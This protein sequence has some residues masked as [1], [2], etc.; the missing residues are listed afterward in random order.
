MAKRENLFDQLCH[1]NLP[2]ILFAILFLASDAYPIS[3]YEGNWIIN[4]EE[5]EALREPY[6]DNSRKRGSRFK[7]QVSV[8]GLPM[9]RS[10]SQRAM[11]RL[12]AQPPM[13]MRSTKMT[14]AFDG[15]QIKIQYPN[16]GQ[17]TLYKGEFRGR[18]TKWSAKQIKQTYKT[19]ERRV[20][21][22]WSINKQGRLLVVVK[23]KPNESKQVITRLVFDSVS[24]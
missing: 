18:K 5:T 13:V 19:T 2:L 24:L 15:D 7:P 6:K 3:A 16:I 17:E 10:N 4:Q 11:S 1:H 14:I 21:K 20:T 22:T 9:P 23:I 12:T 8:G